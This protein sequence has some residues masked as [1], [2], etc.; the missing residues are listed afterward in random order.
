MRL[1][2][3]TAS[4]GG[5]NGEEERL[6]EEL[7]RVSESEQNLIKEKE[8][9]SIELD[10][11]RRAYEDLKRTAGQASVQLDATLAELKALKG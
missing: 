8:G 1:K 4:V 2:N 6:R 5:G 3:E 10:G 11:V 9:L 7:R